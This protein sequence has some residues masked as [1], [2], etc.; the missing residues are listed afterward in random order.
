MWRE[1]S[2][3]CRNVAIVMDRSWVPALPYGAAVPAQR[4]LQGPTLAQ[5]ATTTADWKVWNMGEMRR[6]IAQEERQRQKQDRFASSLIV[7]VSPASGQ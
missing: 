4:N 3:T 1:H 5:A 6:A 2:R 7:A